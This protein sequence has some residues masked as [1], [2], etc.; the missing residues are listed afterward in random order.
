MVVARKLV[1]AGMRIPLAIRE[2]SHRLDALLR[3]RGWGQFDLDDCATPQEAAEKLMNRL[4]ELTERFG[5]PMPDDADLET[6][7]EVFLMAVPP[8]RMPERP[9]ENF[10]QWAANLPLSGGFELPAIR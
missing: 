7:F 4:R 6:A 1:S 9:R 5:R 10:Q 2:T 3:A 8:A